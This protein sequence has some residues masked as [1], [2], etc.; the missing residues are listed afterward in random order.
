MPLG[1]LHRDG[2]GPAEQTALGAL[3]AGEST[4]PKI[5]FNLGIT[6]FNQGQAA[7]A[8]A[9]FKKSFEADPTNLEALYFLG[10]TSFQLGQYADAESCFRKAFKLNPQNRTWADSIAQM[11]RAQKR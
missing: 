9:A 6:H 3:Q 5:L 11:A 7:E 1:P 4:D 2:A 10:N 8:H